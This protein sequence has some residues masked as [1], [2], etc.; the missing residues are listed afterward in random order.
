MS[1]VFK[2]YIESHRQKFLKLTAKQ[3]KELARLFIEAAGDIKEKAQAILDKKSLTYAQAKIRINSLLR[4]AARLSNNFEGVLDRALIEA[5]DLGME[6]NKISMS[7][8]SRSLKANGVNIDM[9]RILSKVN[10]DA[11]AYTYSKIYADGL[12]LS[13]RIWLLEARTKNEIERIIMQNVISGG[14][15]SDKAVISALENLLN[16][17]Y[18]PAKLTSLHGRRVGYE[19][20]RLLRTEMSV[21]FN[22]ANRISAEKNPGSTGL[23]WLIAIGACENCTPLDGLP[24]EKT[25]YPPLHPNCR[26]TT[27]N[28]VQSVEDFTDRYLDFMDNPASDKQLG[29]W[30]LNVYKKAA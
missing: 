9:T 16:P 30:L 13:N 12:M 7:Q 23:T 20:S 8:Y 1:D 15:A 17:A 2:D 10:Y 21:A 27:L 28:E 5:A 11:V 14:S 24:V 6:V 25:G 29:D 22:E 19:A 18:T 3:D 26:C 4:D